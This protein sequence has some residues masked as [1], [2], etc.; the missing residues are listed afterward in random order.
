M[1]HLQY[2]LIFNNILT[3]SFVLKPSDTKIKSF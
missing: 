3:H 2:K 1:R